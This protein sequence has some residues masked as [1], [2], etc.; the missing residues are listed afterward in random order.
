MSSKNS[1]Q[2]SHQPSQKYEIFVGGLP[3]HTNKQ[4]LY[5]YFK[6]FGKITKCQPQRW[7]SGAKKCRGFAIVKCGDKATLDR[8]LNKKDH[9]F[10]GRIIECKP[11]LKKSKLKKYNKELNARK[12]F[13]GCLPLKVTSEI[14]KNFFQKVGAVEMAYVVSDSRG[15]SKGIGFVI[16]QEKRHSDEAI[17]RRRFQMGGSTIICA[18]YRNAFYEEKKKYNPG[19]YRP[20]EEELKRQ[21]LDHPEPRIEEVLN[22][23][24]EANG[25]HQNQRSEQN[26]KSSSK[27]ST[28][29]TESAQKGPQ[30]MEERKERAD[31]E[32][33]KQTSS[34]HITENRNLMQPEILIPGQWQNPDNHLQWVYVKRSK[35]DSPRQEDQDDL[36]AME[37][38]RVQG[39]ENSSQPDREANS[40]FESEN[41]I[42]VLSQSH[43]YSVNANP[44]VSHH[45]QRTRP[46]QIPIPKFSTNFPKEE[47][48]GRGEIYR[49]TAGPNV[50]IRQ[51]WQEHEG[52]GDPRQMMQVPPIRR[53]IRLNKTELSPADYHSLRPPTTEYHIKYPNI[54]QIQSYPG[55]YCLRF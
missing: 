45:H 55:N 37:A 44:S 51:A 24:R 46:N 4:L 13:V 50:Y 31:A 12:V 5:N 53:I 1:I 19:N 33:G 22:G 14:L 23:I 9:F 34:V 30:F 35:L 29:S 2:K 54:S 17:S 18:E 8:I 6:A 16:F 42:G 11:C 36:E 40:D 27:F 15:V 49:Q 7:K 28:R 43:E 47:I 52:P 39:L 41:D 32:R 26:S 48:E 21:R 38:I 25:N 3:S 20:T 10:E